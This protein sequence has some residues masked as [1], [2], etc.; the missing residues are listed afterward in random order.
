MDA[1]PIAAFLQSADTKFYLLLI[2]VGGAARSG[3]NWVKDF[4]EKDVQGIKEDLSAQTHVISSGFNNLTTGLQ[5]LRSDF[6][7]FYTSPD[8]IMVPVNARTPRKR[9]SVTKRSKTKVVPKSA[10]KKPAKAVK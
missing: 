4:R 6:R 10:A 8:P 9:K 3:F 1:N 5:E 2:A 7:T